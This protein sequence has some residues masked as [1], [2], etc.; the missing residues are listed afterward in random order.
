VYN[1]L[2]ISA[3]IE[4][5]A[6]ILWVGGLTSLTLI[7][8]PAIFQSAASRE[9]AGRTF[10]LILKRIHRLGWA[11]G[12]AILLAGGIRYVVRHNQQFY[13]AEYTRYILCAL[14]FALSLHTG[15][16]IARRLD[17]LR[18]AMADGIDR[19]A[20]DDPRRIEFNRLHSQSTA[21]TAFML[22]L[23]LAMA[24]LFGL[25]VH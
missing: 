17:K 11:C 1:L 22:L 16:I 6:L 3:I 12:V 10:G 2:T 23:G 18:A 14:M 13:L 21:V 15:L 9:S 8:A 20:K 24:I 4:I 25:E 5:I 7:A 19:V